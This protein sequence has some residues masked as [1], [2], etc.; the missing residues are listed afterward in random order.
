MAF[1]TKKD[2]I[3]I[4]IIVILILIGWGTRLVLIER[5]NP[6]DSHKLTVIHSAVPLPEGIV[7]PDSSIIA[8]GATGSDEENNVS[9][10]TPGI[11]NI[12]E[13]E[14]EEL[15]TLPMIGEVK[16]KAIMEYR[17]ANGLFKKTEDIMKVKGIGPATFKKL[18][19][20]IVAG[21][22]DKAK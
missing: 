11:V 19:P 5:D 9:Q 12:N 16:A 4:L 3:A 13:A 8:S 1:F 20:Y 17:K 18:K 21:S 14:T 22:S 6:G 15:K 10:N 7:N 2:R